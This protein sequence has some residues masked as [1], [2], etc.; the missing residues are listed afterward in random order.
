MGLFGRQGGRCAPELAAVLLIGSAWLNSVLQVVQFGDNQYGGPALSQRMECGVCPRFFA[1]LESGGI[2]R[3]P[4]A[5]RH[6]NASPLIRQRV[7]VRTHL[8]KRF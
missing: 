1:A 3:T 6:T 4:Y 8:V 7:Y 2:P 5:S